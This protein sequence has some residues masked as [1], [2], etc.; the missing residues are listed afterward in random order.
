MSIQN[1]A[2]KKNSKHE[3]H[4]EGFWF[5]FCAF[6][7]LTLPPPTP[8]RMIKG[9]GGECIQKKVIGLHENMTGISYSKMGNQLKRSNREV[10]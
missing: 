5:L 10:T 9:G 7:Q 4:Q 2:R 1:N 8:A 3:D 6:I